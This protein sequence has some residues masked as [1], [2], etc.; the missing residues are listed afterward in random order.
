M[1]SGLTIHVFWVQIYYKYFTTSGA[2]D[3]SIE[4]QFNFIL[5]YKISYQ[6]KLIFQPFH[7]VTVTIIVFQIRSKVSEPFVTVQRAVI[8]KKKA[9]RKLKYMS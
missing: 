9:Q 5:L 4:P 8:R 7:T 6:I 2:M 1:C 3:L